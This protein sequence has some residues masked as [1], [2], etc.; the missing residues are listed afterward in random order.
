MGNKIENLGG[1]SMANGRFGNR[2]D[3]DSVRLRIYLKRVV[4]KEKAPE[5]LKLRISRMIRESQ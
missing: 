5:E 3:A 2:R 4:L 1:N